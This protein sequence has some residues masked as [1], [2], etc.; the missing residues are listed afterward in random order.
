MRSLTA[1]LF[2]FR[3]WLAMA[4]LAFVAATALA[5]PVTLERDSVLRAEARTDAAVVTNLAKGT[6]GDAVAR[7]GAWVQ[8]KSGAVTGWLY[9]FN[10][11]FGAVNPGG[12]SGA[13]S[14]SALGRVFGPR[15]QVNVTATIGIRGLDEED[16]K[17]A[18]F[19]EGQMRQLDGYAASREQAAAQAGKSGLNA[20]RVE[21]LG[22]SADSAGGSNP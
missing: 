1:K 15:Q 10:V 21:Y 16:L 11:R 17:Q 3:P 8:I 14:G 20:T 9:S 2:R 22:Q 12:S 4:L 5:E 6:T 19:D 18:H 7:Q 13:G